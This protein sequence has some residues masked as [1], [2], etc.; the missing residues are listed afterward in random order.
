MT[1]Q[2]FLIKIGAKTDFKG[3]SSALFINNHLLK[4]EI[5]LDNVSI[6]AEFCACF[7]ETSNI[8]IYVNKDDGVIRISNKEDT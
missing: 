3:Q 6:C 7:M 5:V 8:D 2:E 4:Y 1:L